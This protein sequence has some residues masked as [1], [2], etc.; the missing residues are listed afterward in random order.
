MIDCYN[1]FLTISFNS[2]TEALK[3]AIY[4]NDKYELDGRDPNGFVGCG[5]AIGGVHDRAWPEREVFGKVRYMNAAGL[6]RKF[7]IDEYVQQI[8]LLVQKIGLPPALQQTRKQKSKRQLTMS[9]AMQTKRR[10]AS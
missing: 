2:H 1:S 9:E 5:W 8:E 7:K 4:L 6:K 10:K 3:I